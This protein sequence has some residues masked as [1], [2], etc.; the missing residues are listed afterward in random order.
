MHRK[1][2]RWNYKC[3]PLK[4]GKRSWGVW[5]KSG[6]NFLDTT[7]RGKNLKRHNRDC[8]WNIIN[9]GNWFSENIHASFKLM[10]DGDGRDGINKP[11]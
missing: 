11:S 6:S 7:E 9:E 3:I 8:L 1:I 4:I 2:E 5:N 10:G